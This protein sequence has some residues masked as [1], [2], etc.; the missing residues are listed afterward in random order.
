[1]HPRARSKAGGLSKQ[2]RVSHQYITSLP[3]TVLPLRS[4]RNRPR[5]LARYSITRCLQSEIHPW[6]FRRSFRYFV[7]PAALVG[8][9]LGPS[10]LV[11]HLQVIKTPSKT[12]SFL[13]R[14]FG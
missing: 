5:P 9:A 8:K 14:Q 1:M 11:P 12:D 7:I 4:R 2:R 13:T 3:S 6:F 10:P